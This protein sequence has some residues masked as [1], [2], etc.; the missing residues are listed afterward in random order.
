MLDETRPSDRLDNLSP[1]DD[2]IGE[3]NRLYHA[4]VELQEHSCGKSTASENTSGD[5]SK[6]DTYEQGE[7]K[8]GRHCPEQVSP[9]SA[10]AIADIKQ[11]A[12]ERLYA[13]TAPRILQFGRVIF[14]LTSPVDRDTYVTIGVTTLTA[15]GWDAL[16]ADLHQHK[17][18]LALAQ[19]SNQQMKAR[20]EQLEAHAAG[21]SLMVE[22]KHARI[23]E[24]ERLRAHGVDRLE[25]MTEERNNERAIAVG[26]ESKCEDLQA[27]IDKAAGMLREWEY[28][29]DGNGDQRA[30]W[31]VYMKPILSALT[32]AESE[33]VAGE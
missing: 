19:R 29:S 12:E 20:A 15:E 2:F 33:Q 16:V 24:L 5:F 25:C 22:T 31:D 14:D 26:W 23:A 8:T 30:I 21:C 11:A 7:D 6:P 27:R 1:P 9:E 18:W 10:A 3:L 32:A 28:L 13:E 17:Q 4:I